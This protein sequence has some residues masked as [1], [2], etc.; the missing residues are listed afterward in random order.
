MQTSSIT[1]RVHAIVEAFV[2]ENPKTT[3]VI[4]NGSDNIYEKF[5]VVEAFSKYNTDRLDAVGMKV[6]DDVTV[7]CRISGAESKKEPGRWFTNTAFVDAQ[8]GSSGRT[9]PRMMGSPPEP[10]P[11]N[12]F[13][14]LGGS[15]PFEPISDTDIPI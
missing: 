12:P 5:S 9:G 4:D 3:L 13:A 1:G 7:V 2:G 14:D 15:T 6:G 10:P 8:V 11:S